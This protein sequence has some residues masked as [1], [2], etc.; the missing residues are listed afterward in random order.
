MTHRSAQPLN[1]H[2]AMRCLTIPHC[3]RSVAMLHCASQCSACLSRPRPRPQSP[4]AAL[5]VTLL[6]SPPQ[7]SHPWRRGGCEPSSPDR[8]THHGRCTGSRLHSAAQSMGRGRT[9]RCECACGNGS[10]W[11]VGHENLL[12]SC[13]GQPGG[14]RVRCNTAINACYGMRGPTCR[15]KRMRQRQ[16]L[17]VKHQ[18]CAIGLS[19]EHADILR[20]AYESMLLIKV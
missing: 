20:A 9:R 10:A 18:H 8:R 16:R 13:L 5:P 14:L 4:S 2:R 7:H 11:L 15:Q 17:T 1:R 19:S 6:A 3:G 12:L